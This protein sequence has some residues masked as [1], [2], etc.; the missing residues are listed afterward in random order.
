MKQKNSTRRHSRNVPSDL[1]DRLRRNSWK[2]TGPRRAI[3][4]IL[5]ASA[6]PMTNREIFHALPGERCDLA[7][8]YRSMHLLVKMGMVQRFDFGDGIARFELVH[9]DDHAH[10][11]HLICKECFTVVELEECFPPELEEKIAAQNGFS[12]VT[13]KLEFFGTCPD[14]QGKD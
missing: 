2:L 5:H 10:H 11:H 14:C 13:H 6:H 12:G 8:V 4:E 1:T 9:S 7:T 3:L